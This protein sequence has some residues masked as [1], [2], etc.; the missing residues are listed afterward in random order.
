M[1]KIAVIAGSGAERLA[2]YKDWQ[3]ETVDT[4]FGPV[5]IRK[6]EVEGRSVVF[7]ARHGMEHL[8]A[9]HLINYPAIISA[10]SELG[11]ERIIGTAAVGSL[12]DDIAPGTAT[13][14]TDFIDFT[15]RSPFTIFDTPESGVAHT[16]FTEPYCAQLSE[17]LLEGLE[18][19]GLE[20]TT[21]CTYLCVDGPRYETPAEIAMFRSWGADVIGMTNVPE[22]IL[23]R[24]SGCC[25]GAIAIITNYATGISPTRLSHAEV[26]AMMKSVEKQLSEAILGAI[27]ALPL[28]RRCSCHKS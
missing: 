26:I 25:Y 23:A 4:R 5:H 24:E 10:L 3:P 13:V 20:V 8:V 16:D 22:A 17:A 7:T 11:V 9:P 21:P 28:E 2:P 6:G 18:R 15:R 14:L 1:S 19:S 12:T 27:V